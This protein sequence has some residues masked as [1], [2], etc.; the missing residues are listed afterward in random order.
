AARAMARAVEHAGDREEL[1]AELDRL[2]VKTSS[3]NELGPVLERRVELVFEPS[4]QVEIL[5]RLGELRKTHFADLR[6]AYGAFERVLDAE[7]SEPRAR[8]AL[9][10][11]AKDET[12]AAE[13]VEVLDRAYRASGDL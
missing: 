6:G 11:L 2:Y 4:Q 12:L 7:P 1:L 10:E 8:A 9:I 5:C 13:C 3:W